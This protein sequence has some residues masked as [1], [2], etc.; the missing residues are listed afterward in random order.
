MQTKMLASLPLNKLTI[1]MG[2]VSIDI[3]LVT[4]CL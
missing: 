2:L 1:S 3:Y 4:V